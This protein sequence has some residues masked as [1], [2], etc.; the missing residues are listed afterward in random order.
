MSEKE[1]I[2]SDEEK[3]NKWRTDWDYLENENFPK[4]Y[5][6]KSKRLMEKEDCHSF[7]SHKLI[8]AEEMVIV[9]EDEILNDSET[10]SVQNP[11]KYYEHYE[12]FETIKQMIK[13]LSHRFNI[14]ISKQEYLFK[15]FN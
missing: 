13:W 4:Y 6:D 8:I 14:D 9:L 12:V 1:E 7:H 15:K 10:Y 11:Q 5:I 2:L 3:E